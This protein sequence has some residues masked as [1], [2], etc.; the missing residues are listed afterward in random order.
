[1]DGAAMKHSSIKAIQTYLSVV[2]FSLVAHNSKNTAKAGRQNES[3]ELCHYFYH[4]QL[5]S[6]GLYYVY[7]RLVIWTLEIIVPVYNIIDL[8]YKDQNLRHGFLKK[9]IQSNYGITS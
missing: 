7:L 3:Y 6:T 1:M 8:E 5:N 9:I 4:V 2:F